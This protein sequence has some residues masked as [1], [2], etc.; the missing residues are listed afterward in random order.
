M[1]VVLLILVVITL[2]V[3]CVIDKE[4]ANSDNRG[5]LMQP[6]VTEQELSELR[7]TRAEILRAETQP[8]TRPWRRAPP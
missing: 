6:P 4:P 8:A 1:R 3:V 7:R 5:I 2:L